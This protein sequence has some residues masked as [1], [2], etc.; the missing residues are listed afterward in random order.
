MTP[1]SMSPLSERR[2]G[3]DLDVLQDSYLREITRVVH[4]MHDQAMP[5][6]RVEMAMGII[7]T[8]INPDDL[9]NE[10]DTTQKGFDRVDGADMSFNNEYEWEPRCVLL[11]ACVIVRCALMALPIMVRIAVGDVVPW[12]SYTAIAGPDAD[13]ANSVMS[14]FA[15]EVAGSGFA[16][17]FTL[18]VLLLICLLKVGDV[19]LVYCEHGYRPCNELP[20]IRRWARGRVDDHVTLPA[21]LEMR[22]PLTTTT[23]QST[24]SATESLRPQNEFEDFFDTERSQLIRN[25]EIT[26]PFLVSCGHDD[27]LEDRYASWIGQQDRPFASHEWLVDRSRARCNEISLNM[28]DAHPV[29]RNRIRACRAQG[30]QRCSVAK[31]EVFE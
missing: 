31:T 8:G 1:R 30:Y 18:N 3:S 23:S 7:S 4:L 5:D 6:A 25:A 24:S 19:C 22:D 12:T 17:Y 2:Y 28:S 10:L 14:F 21:D 11:I 26:L 16:I 15:E 13:P 9:S 27:Q 20:L 29:Y